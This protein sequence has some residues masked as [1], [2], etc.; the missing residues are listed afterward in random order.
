MAGKFMSEYYKEAKAIDD[1]E[2]IMKQISDRTADRLFVVSLKEGIRGEKDINK[3][4]N[5]TPIFRSINVTP[6]MAGKFM[7]EHYKKAKA[8]NDNQLANVKPEK[9]L[10]QFIDIRGEFMVFINYYLWLLMDDFNFQIDDVEEMAVSYP[11]DCFE[12]FFDEMMAKRVKYMEEKNKGAEKWC[13]MIMNSSYGFDGLNEEKYSDT[14]LL[15]K[16]KT[17]LAQARGNFVSTRQINDELYIVSSNPY[18][19]GCKTCIQMA[20]FTLANVKYWYLNVLYNHFFR[21][22]D[23]E[24]VHII[25]L[26]TDWCV[27]AVSGDPKLGL[28][29]CFNAIIIDK[30][31]WEKHQYDIMP[32]PAKGKADEKKL[33]GACVENIFDK[34]IGITAKNYSMNRFILC[35]GGY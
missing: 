30:E 4:I 16:E 17:M 2:K 8:I 3:C 15:N 6:Q 21:Y 9:K 12:G 34:F 28:D 18:T 26:D 5:F 27:F 31:G 24:R 14:K 32:N 25:Y 7:S 35:K 1:N 19:F 33:L 22:I 20:L 23:Q 10:T 11:T 29:Q 13:K